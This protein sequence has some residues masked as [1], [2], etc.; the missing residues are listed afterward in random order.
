MPSLTNGKKDDLVQ[1]GL[2]VKSTLARASRL[3][4]WKG[5]GAIHRTAEIGFG[6]ESL[7]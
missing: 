3:S 1:T 7:L 2:Q 5:I 4:H 6:A